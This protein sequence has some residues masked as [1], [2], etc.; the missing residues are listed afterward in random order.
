MGFEPQIRKIIAKLPIERQTLMFTATWPQAVRR[1]ASEFQ[2]DPVEVRIGDADSLTVNADVEQRVIFCADRREKEERLVQIL[3][4]AGDDQV[5]VFVAQKR[6]CDEIAARIPG[7]V[8]IHGDKDQAERDQALAAFKS[9]A[10]RAL[11]A[12]DVAARGL[13]VKGVRLVVNFDP[14]GKEED[15][16]H[17]VG[18]TG[19][20]GQKGTAISFLTSEDGAAAR[21]ISEVLKRMALPVPEELERRLASGEMRMPSERRPGDRARSLPPRRLGRSRGGLGDFGGDDFDFGTGNNE[22]FSAGF[23]GGRS[24]DF[25]TSYNNDCPTGF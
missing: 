5:I 25:L 6:F 22:R 17:R 9:G 10:R 14:A 7:S 23:G 16:V 8:V 24:S 1:L 20:S 18:R 2:R 21:S 13:D 12:T 11:V 19:R 3:R 15:Y 4:D